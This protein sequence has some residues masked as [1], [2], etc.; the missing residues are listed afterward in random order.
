ML[1]STSLLFLAVLAA[2]CGDDSRPGTDSGTVMIDGARPDAPV[3]DSGPRP[4][5]PRTDGPVGP[6]MCGGAVCD[7]LTGGG[8]MTG[9]ACQLV[10]SM[11]GGMPSGMCVP[12]GT[13]GDG[14]PCMGATDC[15]EG[16]AC[17][18]PDGGTMGTCQHYCCPMAAGADT[19][20]PTGQSCATTFA[21]TDVGFCSFPDDCDPLMQT[22]C[23]AGDAC[24]LG[25]GGTYRCATPAADAGGT[26]HPCTYVNDC[27]A[28]HACIMDMCVELCT[29]PGG[30]EC[31][32][33]ATCNGV[34]GFETVGVC[35]APAM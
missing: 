1:R 23:G 11:P 9:Q 13:A 34:T 19:A 28:R 21:S 25:A 35:I 16:F 31:D 10:V 26:G 30:T 20:C 17:V 15:Q 6:G 22:G 24:Y 14:M 4:D 33:P 18:I 7:L 3:G 12:S 32:M 29:I 2:A 8:C 27:L 5:G